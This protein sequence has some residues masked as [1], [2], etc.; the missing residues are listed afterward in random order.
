MLAGMASSWVSHHVSARGLLRRETQSGLVNEARTTTKGTFVSVFSQRE[1]Q[2]AR[3]GERG[4]GREKTCK[5]D[6]L[7]G[8]AY[9]AISV[10]MAL[11]MC[12]FIS[13]A[14]RVLPII[15]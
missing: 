6:P 7:F 5:S 9:E 15:V 12:E 13:I 14:E 3:S 8:N 1:K 2:T 4:R 10:A 11:S